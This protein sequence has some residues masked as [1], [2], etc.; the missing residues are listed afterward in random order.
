VFFELVV[1]HESA[2]RTA[3]REKFDSV[4]EARG[5]RGHAL[6]IDDRESNRD[7][8]APSRSRHVKRN[9]HA[10]CGYRIHAN[11]SAAMHADDLSA[12]WQRNST[13]MTSTR[14]T[15]TR[16]TSTRTTSTRTKARARGAHDEH[17]H[18]EH[19]H[20]EHA[21]DE[22]AHDEHA[23]DEHAHDEH[24]HESTRTT[25]TR[26][27]S[28]RTR[29]TRTRSTRTR[30]TRTTSMRKMSMRGVAAVRF[31]F[32]WQLVGGHGRACCGSLLARRDHRHP[33]QRG[34]RPQPRDG[35][36]A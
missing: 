11:A 25:S 17:A 24:A 8:A 3:H 23:H 34:D 6:L 16:T 12:S 31:I 2:K 21:H 26:T 35:S 14:T 1:R 18:E 30:S 29:S 4:R 36:L 9:R 20:E 19:A 32:T 22:H 5:E 33:R 28:T 13:R 15:S 7:F 10:Q 27:R